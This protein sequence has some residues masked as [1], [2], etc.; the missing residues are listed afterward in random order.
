MI[1]GFLEKLGGSDEHKNTIKDFIKS[2]KDN[3]EQRKNEW[4][5]ANGHNRCKGGEKHK[6]KRALILS[7]PELLEGYPGTVVLAEIE[8]KND[9]HWG[10][11]QGVFLGMDEGVDIEGMPI[12]VVHLPIDREV[13]GQETFKLTVPI[14]I[15]DHALIGQEF[16][17]KL[18]FRGPKGGMFGQPIP[19]K[20]R[21]SESTVQQEVQVPAEVKPVEPLS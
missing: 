21:V 10:W 5:F 9:T 8:V 4:G 12:H 14:T 18:C 3:C 1:S 20:L 15:V 7:K 13:K 19:L 11:K 17:F 2:M 16:E 6:L